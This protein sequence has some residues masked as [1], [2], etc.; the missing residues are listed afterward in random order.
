MSNTN[1]LDKGTVITGDLERAQEPE[2]LLRLLKDLGFTD[3]DLAQAAGMHQRTVR[4]WKVAGPGSA[5]ATHLAELRNIVL[6]LRDAEVLTDRGIVFWM[7]HPNRL[8]EDY[9][10]LV[11]LGAGGFRS[12]REAA[13]CFCNSERSFGEPISASTLG[14]L[15]AP[16]HRPR[17]P[18]TERAPAKRT[19][20]KTRLT[21]V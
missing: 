13:T 5:A 8:L 11:V 2:E 10:P 15:R 17:P 7:R 1:L 20:Q 12:V 9:H 6:L 21:S 19:R 3:E 14:A 16:A 18:K 4:R